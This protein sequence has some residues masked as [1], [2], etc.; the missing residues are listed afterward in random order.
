MRG[1][2]FHLLTDI[3]FN[4]RGLE[5]RNA[6][7]ETVHGACTKHSCEEGPS[8]IKHNGAVRVLKLEYLGCGVC[9]VNCRASG[10]DTILSSLAKVPGVWILLYKLQSISQ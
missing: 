2:R 8:S 3:G 10:N 7:Q 6:T 9:S 5:A 4:S 1:I